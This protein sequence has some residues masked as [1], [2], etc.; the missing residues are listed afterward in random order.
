MVTWNFHVND[1]AKDRYDMILGRD[2]LTELGLNINI[3]DHVIEA[4]DGPLKVYRAP[5]V[6]LGRYEFK[7]LNAGKITTEESLMNSYAE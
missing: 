1:S 2:I 4:Y 5:M 3:Y 6:D 7:G